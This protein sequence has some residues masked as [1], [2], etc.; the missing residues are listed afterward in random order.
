MTQ[1]RLVQV[2]VVISVAADFFP[3]ELALDVLEEVFAG[4]WRARELVVDVLRNGKVAVDTRG[5]ELD[6]ER[7]GRRVVADAGNV[8]GI[9]G[10]ALDFAHGVNLPKSPPWLSTP[11]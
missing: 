7:L 4:R 5:L 10:L 11:V 6:F 9:D 8:A 1:P 3:R 2:G